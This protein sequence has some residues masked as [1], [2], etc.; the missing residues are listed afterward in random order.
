MAE[1]LL[2]QLKSSQSTN[3]LEEAVKQCISAA[4]NENDSA[5]QKVLLKVKE[6]LYNIKIYFIQIKKNI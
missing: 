4:S 6:I 5:I 3:G 2:N 1:M